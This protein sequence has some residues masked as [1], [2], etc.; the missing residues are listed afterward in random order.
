M[1]TA[2]LFVGLALLVVGGAHATTRPGG[3]KG[4]VTRGPITPVCV[5]EQPCTEPA[6]YV[7]LLFSRNS[8]IAGRVVTD[9]E[10]RYRLRLPAGDYSVRRPAAT[11]IDRKLEPNRVRVRAGSVARIDFSIDTGIR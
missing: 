10:G 6:K 5:A 3:L 4:V 9:G 1:R 11:S 2:V 8:H 7:T